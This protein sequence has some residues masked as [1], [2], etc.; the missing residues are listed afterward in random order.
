[1]AK[2]TQQTAKKVDY[3][4]SSRFGSHAN[5][6]IGD[7]EDGKVICKDEFGEYVTEANR[8]DNGASDPNRFDLKHRK[9]KL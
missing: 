6:K 1:M 4:Y 3:P 8:L 5:M 9:V 7:T 2:Q